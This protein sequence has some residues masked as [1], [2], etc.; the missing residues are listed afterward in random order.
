MIDLGLGVSYDAILDA[1]NKVRRLDS[2]DEALKRLKE[3][4]SMILQNHDH[5]EE[6]PYPCNTPILSTPTVQDEI[7]EPSDMDSEQD[8]VMYSD[9]VQ[10]LSLY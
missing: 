10:S 2:G 6:D 7:D 1:I 5:S 3:K 4:I 8:T 9:M